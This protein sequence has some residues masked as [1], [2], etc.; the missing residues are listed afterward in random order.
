M[1]DLATISAFIALVAVSAAYCLQVAWKPARCRSVRIAD[2]D[3]ELYEDAQYLPFDP[4]AGPTKAQK[5]FANFLGVSLPDR[6]TACGAL[7]IID[8]AMADL[9]LTWNARDL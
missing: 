3:Y 8:D 7:D 5:A 6:V 2:L 1:D 9:R 4:K